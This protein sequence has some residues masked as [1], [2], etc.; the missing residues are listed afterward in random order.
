[1]PTRPG[2]PNLICFVFCLSCLL[3]CGLALAADDPE[4]EYLLQAV[5]HSE[6][7]FLRNGEAHDG[8]EAAAH[9]RKKYEYRRDDID[10]AE[11]FIAQAASG[12]WLSGEPYRVQLADG[13]TELTRDWLSARLA[14]YR[15]RSETADDP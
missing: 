5:A 12:S 2:Y 13:S 9:L 11:A 7:S 8:P 10:G 15:Q 14:E 6:H 4:I 3:A 1:M